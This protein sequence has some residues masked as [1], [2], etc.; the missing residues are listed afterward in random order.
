MACKFGLEKF[1][2]L[3][4]KNNIKPIKIKKINY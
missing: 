3:I 1:V 4:T 2:K